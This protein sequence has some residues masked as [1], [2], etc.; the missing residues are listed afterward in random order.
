MKSYL[1]NWL[2]KYCSVGEC[3]YFERHI[4]I[5]NNSSEFKDSRGW[6]KII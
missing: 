5:E 2:E 3:F 1:N 4:L 6:M